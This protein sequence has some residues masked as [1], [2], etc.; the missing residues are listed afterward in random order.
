MAGAH[1][2]SRV[3]YEPAAAQSDAGGARA[4]SPAMRAADEEVARAKQAESRF[5]ARVG[6]TPRESEEPL[7]FSEAIMS[8]AQ[9][10]QSSPHLI[11]RGAD[12]L[13]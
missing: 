9:E 13:D 1:T 12:D 2:H 5:L 11:H 10:E 4:A 6:T 8:D 3:G 7:D